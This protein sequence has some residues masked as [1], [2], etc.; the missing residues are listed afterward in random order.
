MPP[1]GTGL[2]KRSK[3]EASRI[4]RARCDPGGFWEQH[5]AIGHLSTRLLGS[6]S[7]KNARADS[8]W[9]PLNAAPKKRQACALPPVFAGIHPGSQECRR[10]PQQQAQWRSAGRQ[11]ARAPFQ[12]AL[13][14]IDLVE[15][16][17]EALG[18][19]GPDVTKSTTLKGERSDRLPRSMAS[20]WM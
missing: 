3:P 8:G 6:M 15:F 19:I 14:V 10:R 9:K 17:Q 18:A 2:A 12:E 11:R 1:V 20:E 7:R 4:R 5:L 16:I 13:G